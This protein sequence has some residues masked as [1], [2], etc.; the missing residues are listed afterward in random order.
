MNA[1]AWVALIA[2]IISVVT[3]IVQWISS[4]KARARSDELAEQQ[5]ALQERL[6]GIEEARRLDE[7]RPALELKHQRVKGQ[8]F[9]TFSNDGPVD[10]DDVS[11]EPTQMP[12]LVRAGFEFDESVFRL[13]GSIGALRIGEERSIRLDEDT[14]KGGGEL[15]LRVTCRSGPSQW[16]VPL[17]CK[18]LGFARV[19]RLR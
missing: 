11:F 16:V 15:V 14:T 18:V 4:R 10:L 2:L 5:H 7:T 3:A 19:G 12:T 17:R 6:A 8:G 13:S 1:E 9:L